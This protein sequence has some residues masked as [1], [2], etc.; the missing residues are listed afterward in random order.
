MSTSRTPRQRI[1]ARARRS[2]PAR[3]RTWGVVICLAAA[4]SFTLAV[5]PANAAAVPAVATGTTGSHGAAAGR[6]ES[7]QKKLTA[8]NKELVTYVYQQLFDQADLAVIGS[9]IDQYFGPTY[10]QHNPTDPDGVDALRGLVVFLHTTF[11]E[12]HTQIERVVAEGDLVLL[13]SHA[14]AIPGTNGQNI[15]DIFRV[16]NGRIVEHWDNLSDV[17]DTT[18]SGHDQFSTLSSPQ[19]SVA[20]PKSSTLLNKLIVKGY[21]AAVTKYHDLRAVDLIDARHLYQHDPNIADGSAATRQYYANI[22]AANPSATFTV[23]R[24]IAEGDLVAVHSHF[25]KTPTDLGQ[26][27]VDIFRVR[28]GKIVEH[29]DGIQDVPATSANDNTMF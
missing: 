24:V 2:L 29:W 10:T 9:V 4:T 1:A 18:V 3:I 7:A 5:S 13:Q 21:F 17:S 20:D 12:L 8:T 22:F 27:V 23:A 26:S 6:A 14:V 28:G 25:Q 16:A 19:T 15:I 11:P